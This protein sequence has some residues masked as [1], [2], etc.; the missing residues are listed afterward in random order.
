MKTYTMIYEVVC[1][2]EIEV[3]AW[4]EDEAHEDAVNQIMTE[5]GSTDLDVKNVE[6]YDYWK[7]NE[8]D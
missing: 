1:R 3:T 2:R 6:L 7:S 8:Q 4:N 5:L